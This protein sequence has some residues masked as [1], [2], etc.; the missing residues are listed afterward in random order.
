[1]D[2]EISRKKKSKYEKKKNHFTPQAREKKN[3]KTLDFVKK[4]LTEKKN[5]SFLLIFHFPCFFFSKI[6]E[7]RKEFL[8]IE[9][10]KIS[11]IFFEKTF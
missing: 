1:M 3:L 8:F 9:N 7:S 6:R 4:F 10:S 5:E 2:Y 11:K